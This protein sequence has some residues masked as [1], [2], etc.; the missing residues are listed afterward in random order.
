VIP[1]A[2]F[3]PDSSDFDPSVTDTVVNVIPRPSSYGPFPGFATA[4][5][6][7]PDQPRGAFLARTS[8]GAYRTFAFT[9]DAIYE[10]NGA[11]RD[12]D[13]VSKAATTYAVPSEGAWSVVQFGDYVIAVNGID[14]NQYFD[15]G[16]STEFADLAGTPPKATYAAVV[17]DFL[18]LGNTETYGARSVAWGGVNDA[19]FWEPGRRGSDYQIFPEGGEV[20]GIAGFERGAVV[21]QDNV[22]REQTLN[23]ASPFIFTF[24]KT[25]ETRTIVAPRSITRAGGQIFFLTLE[26]FF[27]YGVPSTPIGNERVDRFFQADADIEYLWQ[28]QGAADPI[29]KIV[30]WRYKSNNSTSATT[31]DRVLIYNYVLD[32]WSLANVELSWIFSSTTPGVTLEGLDALGY[33]LDTL[34]TS[35]DSRTFAGGTPLIGGFNASYE[36]G[37]FSGAPLE[38]VLQTGDVS[39]AP[40]RAFVRGFRPVCDAETITGRVAV[41]DRHGI[42]R[43]WSD[44]TA[45][46]RTGLIPIRASGRL[47]R[48]EVTIP[49]NETWE[50]AHGVTPDAAP[51]GRQ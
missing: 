16:S 1:F 35:L 22:I 26:G 3:C 46:E 17:G 47:H 21:F 2:P 19:E 13:D 38:A 14:D 18:T 45:V 37:F 6:A 12:W 27:R 50:H 23:L 44:A 20:L 30:Y 33:T 31:T 24:N 43:T 29:N 48:F 40:E 42:E 51:E 5:E 10:F 36:L 49:A 11:T 28:V 4:S 25:D 7:L 8:A 41:K 39:I 15:L 9:E 32:R 34:P